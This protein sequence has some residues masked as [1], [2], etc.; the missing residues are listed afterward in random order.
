MQSSNCDCGQNGRKC[1][2]PF[3]HCFR[4]RLSDS[5]PAASVA[6]DGSVLQQ[7]WLLLLLYL[8][9]HHSNTVVRAAA[10]EANW[11]LARKRMAA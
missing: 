2:P 5:T 3:F 11:S 6:V 1:L 8:R 10:M 7:L 4:R 9:G